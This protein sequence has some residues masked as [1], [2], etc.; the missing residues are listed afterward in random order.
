MASYYRAAKAG[1]CKKAMRPRKGYWPTSHL[2]ADRTRNAAP[3]TIF[4]L[5]IQPRAQF[6]ISCFSLNLDLRSPMFLA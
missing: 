4:L 6:R 5:K 3:A 2:Y 1:E